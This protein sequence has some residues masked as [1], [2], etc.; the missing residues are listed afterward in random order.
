MFLTWS[1]HWCFILQIWNRPSCNTFY[2][3]LLDIDLKSRDRSNWHFLKYSLGHLLLIEQNLQKWKKTPVSVE[4]S[5]ITF[6]PVEEP[7]TSRGKGNYCFDCAPLLS[8]PFKCMHYRPFSTKYT[9]DFF[10][11]YNVNCSVPT[12][13]VFK[14]SET[15]DEKG[16]CKLLWAEILQSKG[17]G[18]FMTGYFSIDVQEAVTRQECDSGC[19]EGDGRVNVDVNNKFIFVSM[20]TSTDSYSLGLT[21]SKILTWY[22]L[23]KKL[24]HNI[25]V[26]VNFLSPPAGNGAQSCELHW[27]DFPFEKKEEALVVIASDLRPPATTSKSSPERGSA[28]MT[29]RLAALWWGLQR[30]T[31]SLR[32]SFT[33]SFGHTL[34]RIRHKHV[35]MHLAYS[36][37]H[38]WSWFDMMWWP[39]EGG[40]EGETHY[41]LKWKEAQRDV[42]LQ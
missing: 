26:I 13:N 32:V 30:S 16:K 4:D 38:S 18:V 24:A 36:P 34:T 39:V 31:R 23:T 3:I 37:P 27:L 17:H 10:F 15:S 42:K 7:C 33:G 6:C 22:D 41:S 14:R 20:E 21:V 11:F 19:K 25:F 5:W 8:A 9:L 1:Y 35:D 40:Q 2:L 28:T 12:S 29:G